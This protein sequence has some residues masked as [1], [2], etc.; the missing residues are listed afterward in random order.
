MKILVKMRDRR[1]DVDATLHDIAKQSERIATGVGAQPE[2][3]VL[4][5][6]DGHTAF[7]QVSE[8]LQRDRIVRIREEAG[9]NPGFGEDALRISP[10]FADRACNMHDRLNAQALR[11]HIAKCA[12]CRRVARN[13]LGH[14]EPRRH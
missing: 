1:P 7:E 11:L 10:Q 14:A 5:A 2:A 13:I 9:G 6:G 8:R 3:E 4:A 12:G